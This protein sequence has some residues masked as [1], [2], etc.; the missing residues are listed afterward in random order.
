[1]TQNFPRGIEVLLKKAAVDA[2]FCE[3]LKRDRHEAANLIGLSLEEIETNI[4]RSI[5]T[6]Q[7]D[8]LIR[9]TVV[10]EEHRETFRGNDAAAMSAI[11]EEEQARANYESLRCGGGIRPQTPEPPDERGE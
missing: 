11:L 9:Q 2:E 6:G 10:P 8:A 7:L 1:M 3:R 5:P 4:L